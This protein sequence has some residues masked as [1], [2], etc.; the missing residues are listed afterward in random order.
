MSDGVPDRMGEPMKGH[1]PPGKTLSLSANDMV[2]FCSGYD[3]MISKIYFA[4]HCT[5]VFANRLERDT[6]FTVLQSLEYFYAPWEYTFLSKTEM[7]D[8]VVVDQWHGLKIADKSALVLSPINY[9]NVDSCEN[10]RLDSVSF[11]LCG[12]KWYVLTFQ[13]SGARDGDGGHCTVTSDLPR[14]KV[15]SADDVCQ[16]SY[17]R[18]FQHS[19]TIVG[20]DV[21]F[22]L[23]ILASACT[24]LSLVNLALQFRDRICNLR[25]V[26][27]ERAV[28][29]PGHDTSLTLPLH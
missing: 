2:M 21:N 17:E 1:V 12:V 28:E 27:P 18:A 14:N 9:S 25:E 11:T 16:E 26:R 7:F 15:L 3:M 20:V 8:V 4:P 22:F 24:I 19:C 6:V 23:T 29:I 5:G 13:V 10:T